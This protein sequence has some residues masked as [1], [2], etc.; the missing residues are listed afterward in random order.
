[1]PG[2]IATPRMTI[3]TASAEQLSSSIVPAS[4]VRIPDQELGRRH[5]LGRFFNEA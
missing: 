5:D 2:W 1:M 4:P 3:S